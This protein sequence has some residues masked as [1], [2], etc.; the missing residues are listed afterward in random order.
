M[1]LLLHIV[2]ALS[3]LVFSSYAYFQPSERLLRLSYGLVGI[4]LAS[5]TFLVLSQSVNI[6]SVCLSGLLYIVVVAVS[7]VLAR[8]KMAKSRVSS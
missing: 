7:L 1:V 2:S 5:G 8:Q 3:S 6:L 4:T